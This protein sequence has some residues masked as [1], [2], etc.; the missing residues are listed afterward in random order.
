MVYVPDDHQ[1][2]LD[3]CYHVHNLKDGGHPGIA[4]TTELIKR[5]FYFPAME[6]FIKEYVLGCHT[7]QRNKPVHHR[8]YGELRP[9]PIP[10]GPWQS[11]SMDAV[12][13]LPTSDSYDCVYVF[14]DR[15]TKMAVFVPYTEKGFT[16][17]ALADIFYRYVVCWF[18][19][20]K[21]I[22]SD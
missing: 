6:K 22:V 18:G 14:V 9:L 2:K 16:A 5:H 13:K 1:L 20:P 17:T 7:C 8:Q 3:V 10:S 12:T 4:K 19:L 11:V 15:F 21:D